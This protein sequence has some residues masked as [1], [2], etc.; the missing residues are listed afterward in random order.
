MTNI[1]L[2]AGTVL[3]WGTSWLAIKYQLGIVAPEVS[4]LY[5][6]VL[7]AAI[8]M[9]F[10]LVTRRSMR[11]TPRQHLFMAL[12]GGCLFSTNYVFVYLATQYLT[13]GLVAVAFC[14]VTIMTIVFGAL[15]F[16]FPIRPRVALGSVVGLGGIALVFWPEFGDFDLSRG[17]PLGLLLAVTGTASAAMGMLLSARNQRSGMPVM[18]NNAFSMVYGMTLLTLYCS[19]KG[20]PFN[21]DFSPAYVGSLLYLGLF[22][23]VIAFWCYLTLVGRIG[24][25]KAAYASVMF[26]IVAL[27]LSTLVEGFVWTAP[28]AAGVVLVLAGNVLILA[29]PKSAP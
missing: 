27:A 8:M 5:R 12:Q 21:F 13:S 16:G 25:D 17:G 18:Q 26:P 1:L 3:L 29:A 22:S 23:T 2:Y 9:A 28:A 6:F 24:P 15:F 14:T 10:C 19:L 4:V 20:L 11:F 7:A